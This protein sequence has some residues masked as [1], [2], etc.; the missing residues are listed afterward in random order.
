MKTP[1]EIY[2][3][4]NPFWLSDIFI[5]MEHKKLKRTVYVKVNCHNKIEEIGLDIEK[6]MHYIPLEDIK[7]N[8][9]CIPATKL[10]KSILNRIGNEYWYALKNKSDKK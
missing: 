10:H 4:P 8:K 6:R 9:Y 2:E 3:I 7:T 1:K 5:F